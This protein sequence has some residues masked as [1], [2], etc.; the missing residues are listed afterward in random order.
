MG[1]SLPP[2]QRERGF[3]LIELLTVIAIIAILMG[4]LFPALNSAKTAA[5]KSQARTDETSLV[6]ACHAY[7]VDYGVYPLNSQNANGGI[8][9]GGGWD[10][11]YGDNGPN[12]LY[13]SADLC[14]ILR[15]VA[16]S[17]WN[18]NNQLNSRQVVYFEPTIAKNATNPRGGLVTAPNGVT[19]PVGNQIPYGAYVDPWGEEYVVFL[20]SNYDGSLSIPPS[21][22]AYTE[23]AV[24][25]FYYDSPQN[26]INV[27]CGVAAVSLGPDCKW[28]TGGNA[29]FQGSDDVASWQ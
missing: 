4:L 2:D 12:R 9:G 23:A 14:D 3:T 20:D 1:L 11:C 25:W 19:G 28:G 22:Q 5:R 10:T 6:N 8:S 15:A 26:S 21:G 7:Y 17:K 29:I 13:S 16:D 27:N 18:T 24:Y